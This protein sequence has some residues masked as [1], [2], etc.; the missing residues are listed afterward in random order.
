MK[1]RSFAIALS[2]LLAAATFTLAAAAKLSSTGSSEVTFQASG[3]AGMK[4]N[5]SGAG[6]TASE[7]D[8][9]LTIVAPVTDLKTG[10]G[11]RDNH[12]RKY[13]KANKHPAAKLVVDKSKLKMP[14]DGATE[15]GSASG[16]FTLAGVTKDLKFKYRVKR[17]GSDYHVKGMAEVKITD[18]IEQPC[19]LGVCV[20]PPV[21]FKVNFK[22][23]D[24]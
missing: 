8:G 14:A 16:Q 21:K 1:R 19:Y 9:K 15:E 22:L 12:L 13:L 10:I 6:L 24:K 3:P 17:T 7:D 11:L 23:R 18:Y 4:I 2:T 5:G 20:E